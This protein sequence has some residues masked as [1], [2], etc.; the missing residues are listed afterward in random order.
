MLRCYLIEI[1][2][3]SRGGY[4]GVDEVVVGDDVVQLGGSGVRIW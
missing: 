3:D 1:V 2:P 4:A